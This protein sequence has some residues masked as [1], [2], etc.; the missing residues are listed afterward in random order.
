VI[1]K[2]EHRAQTGYRLGLLRVD[3]AVLV[4]IRPVTSAG[5]FSTSSGVEGRGAPAPKAPAP[6]A[7]IPKAIVHLT[8]VFM[9]NLLC[10]VCYPAPLFPPLRKSPVSLGGSPDSVEPIPGNA[11]PAL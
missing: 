9:A 4:L 2:R 3:I 5:S 10:S 11:L 6:K 7:I 1:N 8:E